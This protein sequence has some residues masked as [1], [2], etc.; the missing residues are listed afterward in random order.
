M[1]VCFFALDFASW[2]MTNDGFMGAQEISGTNALNSSQGR[3]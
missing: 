1:F 2:D 3:A